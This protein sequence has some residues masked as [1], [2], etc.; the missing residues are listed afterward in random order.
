MTWQ[1]LGGAVVG[2]AMFG[3]LFLVA[4]ALGTARPGG[5]ES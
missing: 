4:V 1:T 2:V 3:L 5:R